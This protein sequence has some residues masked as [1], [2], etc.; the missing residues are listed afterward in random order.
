MNDSLLNASLVF[1][2][3]TAAF[4]FRALLHACSH[5]SSAVVV[6]SL[7]HKDSRAQALNVLLARAMSESSMLLHYVSCIIFSIG[8]E[9]P[10]HNRHETGS[11]LVGLLSHA[12]NALQSEVLGDNSGR[13]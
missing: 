3:C 13:R 12:A 5:K 7:Q 1:A 11:V 9:G 2:M 6:L 10:V 4:R 8:G